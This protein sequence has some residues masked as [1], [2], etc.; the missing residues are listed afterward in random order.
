MSDDKLS[1]SECLQQLAITADRFGQVKGL[2]KACHE[3]IKVVEAQQFLLAEG[4]SEMR[5]AKARSS[6][7]YI[8]KVEQLEELAIEEAILCA[9]R[10]TW[11]LHVEVWRS[12]NANR[13]MGNIT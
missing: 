3:Y 12:Q 1:V 7:E 11:D 13:R 9:K 10:A 2:L 4:S 8:K 5:K 6:P